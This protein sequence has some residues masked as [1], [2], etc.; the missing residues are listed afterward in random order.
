MQNNYLLKVIALVVIILSSQASKA[1]L[2]ETTAEKKI[3]NPVTNAVAKK[4]N[5]SSL[6]K[7]K[8]ILEPKE[9]LQWNSDPKNI[10]KDWIKADNKYFSVFYPKCFSIEMDGQGE[11]DYRTSQGVSLRRMPKCTNFNEGWKESNWLSINYEYLRDVKNVGLK[12]M[13]LGT[14][15]VYRQKLNINTFES[16][17]GAT[18]MN[19][20]D[21]KNNENTIQLRWQ[22]IIKCKN[23]VFFAGFTVPSGEPSFSRFENSDYQ[24]PD[25]FKQ[26]ISTFQ[27]NP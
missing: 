11:D 12:T 22:V 9:S 24:A 16:F 4:I 3:Q 14:H 7:E 13:I 2:Q 21:T 25:D 26:I 20:F 5:A 17:I 8:G 6:A 15:F 19:D 27:C 1:D 18:I 23:K 10:P